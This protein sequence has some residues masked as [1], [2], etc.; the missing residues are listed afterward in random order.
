M[1]LGTFTGMGEAPIVEGFLDY[2]PATAGKPCQ[3]WY[4]VHGDL[5]SGV[6]PLVVVHGGP[7]LSHDYMDT[8]A[9]L[10]APPYSVPMVFYDQIGGGRST[11]LPEKYRDYSFWNEQLFLDELTALLSHLGIQGNYD[12]LG[13]SW[14]GMLGSVHAARQPQGLKRLV[15]SGTPSSG[16]AWCR[17]YRR[18]RE[19]M[20]EPQRSILKQARDFDTEDTPEYNEAIEMFFRR[21]VVNVVP[22]PD[23]FQRSFQFLEKDPTVAHST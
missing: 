23:G 2:T 8:I 19:Q 5:K 6:R 10:A 7:G 14:G 17:A 4:K 13:N 18:Y 12:L 1:T 11:K 9:D 15:I 3:T 22:I 21:H 20:P 16:A